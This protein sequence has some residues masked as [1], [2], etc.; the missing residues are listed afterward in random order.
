MLMANQCQQVNTVNIFKDND[1]KRNINYEWDI[2]VHAIQANGECLDVL[3]HSHHD[4]CPS[5]F[6]LSELGNIYR[7]NEDDQYPYS[8]LRQCVLVL[9]R[10]VWINEGAGVFDLDDRTWAY[11][12]KDDN[13]KWILPEYFNQ[14][15]K[16]PK[17]FHNE[18]RKAQIKERITT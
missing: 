18:L 2:E 12:E 9:V 10:D 11:A 5:L 15:V 1:M 13:A 16:V 6:Q 8:K 7:A 4:K 3:D 17:R 14:G